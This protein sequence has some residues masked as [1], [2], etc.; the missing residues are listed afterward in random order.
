I[1][2]PRNAFML[3]RSDFW[4]KQKITK[5]VEADHRHISRIIGHCWSELSEE[6]KFEWRVKADIEKL[7]HAKMYPNYRFTP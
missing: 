6:E 4:A 7:E 3:F 1:P 2:R 5:T